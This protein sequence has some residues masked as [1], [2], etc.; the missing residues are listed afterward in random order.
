MWHYVS[1]IQNHTKSK[2]TKTTEYAALNRR[3]IK[4]Q[5]QKTTS[6]TARAARLGRVICSNYYQP[7][8]PKSSL[9]HPL[10]IILLVLCWSYVKQLNIHQFQQ[11]HLLATES[12]TM[13]T[14][15]S[16]VKRPASVISK[17]GDNA[18]TTSALEDE[19]LENA[20]NEVNATTKLTYVDSNNVIPKKMPSFRPWEKKQRST[21]EEGAG[22]DYPT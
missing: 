8:A 21:A 1:H 7:L 6:I 14:I 10:A 22:V 12:D 20:I 17:Q 16:L 15:E 11:D 18:K 3:K 2:N 19:A 4:K 13:V 5:K 9:I